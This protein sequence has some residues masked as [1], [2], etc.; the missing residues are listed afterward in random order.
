[1]AH[2]GISSHRTS[3]TQSQTDSQLSLG[4]ST[5]VQHAPTPSNA[6]LARI[7][8]LRHQL[9]ELKTTMEIRTHL[10]HVQNNSGK[11]CISCSPEDLPPGTCG[12]TCPLARPDDRLRMPYVD[13]VWATRYEED[14]AIYNEIVTD[15]AA[16]GTA[17]YPA[18]VGRWE[19]GVQTLKMHAKNNN[20][21]RP[22]GRPLPRRPY[23]PG[24]REDW[25]F[26]D[27]WGRGE[28]G[29]LEREASPRY[30]VVGAWD[31]VLENAADVEDEAKDE[32]DLT[33]EEGRIGP[34]Q[35]GLKK[36]KKCR[37]SP[38]CCECQ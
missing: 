33:P 18:T 13:A 31:A 28:P 14:L 3:R 19:R 23:I 37:L 38:S 21:L 22:G 30:E 25:N 8:E 4:R 10:V 11:Y 9:G 34:E 2:R 16:R 20:E 26:A 12:L 6:T 32:D 24:W 35:A 15:M 17:V 27:A 1:M 7:M 5:P 29:V 36:K